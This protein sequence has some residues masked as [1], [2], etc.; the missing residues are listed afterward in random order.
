MLWFCLSFQINVL[1]KNNP[2]VPYL[3]K[4]F[5]SESPQRKIKHSFYQF[6]PVTNV[7]LEILLFNST[8]ILTIIIQER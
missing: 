3:A 6:D 8:D 2:V 1:D 4:L 7:A 5:S